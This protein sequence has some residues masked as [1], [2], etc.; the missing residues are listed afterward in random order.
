MP[1]ARGKGVMHNRLLPPPSLERI[2]TLS[3]QIDQCVR[4][5]ITKAQGV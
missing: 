3:G 5:K 1:I 4:V 2:D